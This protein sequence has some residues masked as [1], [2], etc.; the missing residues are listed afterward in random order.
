MAFKESRHPL[1]AGD[2]DDIWLH[3]APDNIDAADRLLDR[4]GRVLTML[5]DNPHAG[6]ERPELG[7]GVRS[8]PIANFI[9]FYRPTELRVEFLRALHGARDISGDDIDPTS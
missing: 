8:F 4:I 6:R 2:L 1:F 5:L 7:Q 9:V 3:I